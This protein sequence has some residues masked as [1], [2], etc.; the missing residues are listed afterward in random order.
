[1]ESLRDAIFGRFDQQDAYYRAEN[2]RVHER[3]DQ[4]DAYYR[5]ENARVH[6]RLDRQDGAIRYVMEQQHIPVPDWFTYPYQGYSP[7]HGPYGGQGGAGDDDPDDCAPANLLIPHPSSTMQ[8][9]LREELRFESGS[10]SDFED[11]IP[12]YAC[13][14]YL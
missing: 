13:Q 4:Q 2:A 11:L 12:H 14:F 3:F 8:Q 7:Y 10:I 9:G 6:E 1:M 5:A